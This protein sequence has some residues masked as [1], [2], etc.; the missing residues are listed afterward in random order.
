VIGWLDGDQFYLHKRR[1]WRNDFAPHCYGNFVDQDKGTLIECYFDLHR[2]TRLFMNLWLTLAIL[3]GISI[4]VISIRDLL[5]AGN[6][7]DSGEYVGLFVP[8]AMTLFGIFLPK[9]RLLLG[10]PE[11][12]FILGFLE[13][14][15]V[16]RK[17]APTENP[18]T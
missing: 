12:E 16:P 15:L 14:T 8:V 3:I 6:F 2:W 11:E 18:T 4:F 1:I 10:K 17:C 13:R 9:F 5:H 7:N